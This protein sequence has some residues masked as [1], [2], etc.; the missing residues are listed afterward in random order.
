VQRHNIYSAELMIFDIPSIGDLNRDL[1]YL[2]IE[3]TTNDV[4]YRSS[5]DLWNE[6]RRSTMLLRQ[7]FENCCKVYLKTTVGG[8]FDI[9]LS[10]CWV[11]LDHIENQYSQDK[12]YHIHNMD[13]TNNLVC[14]YYLKTDG[15]L[16]GRASFKMT[17]SMSESELK[18][19]SGQLIILPNWLKH[20]GECI[21]SIKENP[22]ISIACNAKYYPK[23]F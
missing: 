20:R 10:R 11:N 18:L 17:D 16:D 12:H 14:V 5:Y 13:G 21:S 23:D 8:S 19:K 9:K 3:K 15:E 6:R 7:I 2:L 4:C 1:L 22:R